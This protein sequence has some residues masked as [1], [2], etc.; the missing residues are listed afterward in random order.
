[1]VL[2]STPTT[3]LDAFAQPFRFSVD[4]VYEEMAL[5]GHCNLEEA[6]SMIFCPYCLPRLLPPSQKIKH[7][8]T[9]AHSRIKNN[10]TITFTSD[11]NSKNPARY[12]L[13]PLP[14]CLACLSSFSA[15]TL[16][17]LLGS[18]CLVMNLTRKTLFGI[19]TAHFPPA[20]T[21]TW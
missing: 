6:T 12:V 10:Q 11:S 2:K 3:N 20:V 18:A 14:R 1:M 21:V 16:I 13:H 5:I 17:R 19:W 7:T 8:K 9:H 4:Q 15:F